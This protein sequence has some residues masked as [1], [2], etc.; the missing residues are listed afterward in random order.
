MDK[1]WGGPLISTQPEFPPVEVSNIIYFPVNPE[2]LSAEFLRQKYVVENLSLAELAEM[3]G[4]AKSTVSKYLKRFD[5]PMRG[6]GQNVRPVRTVR[7]GYRLEGRRVV[8]HAGEQET[9]R[10]MQNLREEGYSYWRVADILNTMKVPTKTR[11][12]RWHARSVKQVLE[13]SGRSSRAESKSRPE[14]RCSL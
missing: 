4:P 12:G 2:Y 7:Y 14:S 1:E 8:P 10:K 3:I 6:T 9:I 11:K 13:S 5:I